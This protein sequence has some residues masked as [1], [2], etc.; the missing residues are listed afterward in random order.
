MRKK[1][2]GEKKEILYFSGCYIKTM[3]L[4]YFD[5][6]TYSTDATLYAEYRFKCYTPKIPSLFVVQRMRALSHPHMLPFFW[7]CVSVTH[8]HHN[9][10]FLLYF[11]YFIWIVFTYDYYCTVHFG[12]LQCSVRFLKK[13]LGVLYELNIFPFQR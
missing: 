1:T 13:C 12:T 7:H 5:C 4:M 10:F 3:I 2:Q 11:I 8:I 6:Y 9:I